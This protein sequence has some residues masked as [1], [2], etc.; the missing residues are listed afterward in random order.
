MSFAP[1]AFKLFYAARHR[2]GADA[3]DDGLEKEKY[4]RTDQLPTRHGS[5]P[6]LHGSPNLRRQNCGLVRPP[7]L[8]H[9]AGSAHVALGED[10]ARRDQCTDVE[11]LL[12]QGLLA[13]RAPQ[14]RRERLFALLGLGF[15]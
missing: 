3:G 14:M 5:K 11:E 1:L 6:S 9:S 7:L 2:A 15:R 10:A 8:R 4:K 13:G 12:R